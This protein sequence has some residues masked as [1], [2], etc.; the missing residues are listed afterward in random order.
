MID[1]KAARANPD[2]FRGAVARKGAGEAFDALLAAD[3]RWRSLV[4]QVD[5]L[6]SRQ[7]LDGRPTPEQIEELKRVKADLKRLE[8][9]LAAAESER[10]AL[11]LQVPNPPH[12]SVPDGETE[13]DADEISRVGEPPEIAEPKDHLELGRF[14]MERAARLS[15]SRF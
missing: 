6:R 15:G 2:A 11:A 9:A 5:D 7:K 10:D 8:D 12:E 4:P 3:A 13:E 14:D 1:L